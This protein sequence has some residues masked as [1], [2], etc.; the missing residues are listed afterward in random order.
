[1]PGEA[2]KKLDCRWRCVTDRQAISGQQLGDVEGVFAISFGSSTGLRA[3][4]SRIGQDKLFNDRFEHFPQPAVKSRP[5]RWPRCAVG[6]KRQSSQRFVAGT[7]RRFLRKLSS[8][9]QRPQSTCGERVPVQ[10]DADTVMIRS[11]DSYNV[12]LHVRGQR[13]HLAAEKRNNFSW[14]LHGFYTCGITGCDCNHWDTRVIVIAGRSSRTRVP[15]VE[16]HVRLT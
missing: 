12:K 7:C 6:T 15:H 3:G 5:F 1:M 16:P 9:Q 4:L 2:L 14:P 8:Q 11:R 10:V 13:K